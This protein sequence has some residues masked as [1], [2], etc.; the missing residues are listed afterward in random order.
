MEDS[1]KK[2]AEAPKLIPVNI[3]LAG[4]SYRILIPPSEEAA[5]R[6]SVKKADEQIAELRQHY[7]G[8]DDQDF[9]AMCLLMYASADAKNNPTEL[10][11]EAL[12]EMIARIDKVLEQ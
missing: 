6:R 2:E 11:N 4:R 12:E 5:L 10:I 9:V 7:A 3:W 1:S 8:K